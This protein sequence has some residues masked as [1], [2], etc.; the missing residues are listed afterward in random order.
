MARQ[1]GLSVR[2]LQSVT[3]AH[4][5]VTPTQL[6]REIRL[7]SARRRLRIADPHGS[8]VASIAHESGF[9]HVGRFSTAYVQRFGEYPAATLRGAAI[10]G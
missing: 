10:A 9:A 8:T 6:L 7:Q 2:Q 5:G 1:M 4:L 3:H